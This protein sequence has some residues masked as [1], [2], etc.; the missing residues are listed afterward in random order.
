M[1]KEKEKRTTVE[2]AAAA[3]AVSVPV[4]EVPTPP[5]PGVGVVPATATTSSSK[6]DCQ[7]SSHDTHTS[8]MNE[9]DWIDTANDWFPRIGGSLSFISAA[10]M[11]VMAWDRRQFLVHSLVLGTSWL[12]FEH[13][14]CF[15]TQQG[16]K[17]DNRKT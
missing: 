3:A 14:T 1:H 4:S 13:N 12:Q 2:A 7:R 5:T 8:I 11:V 15:G 6:F 16:K 10:Y 17:V 9:P